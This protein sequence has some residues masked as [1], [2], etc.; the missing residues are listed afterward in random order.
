[1]AQ[2]LDL[3][4]FQRIVGGARRACAHHAFDLNTKLVAHVLG[5][6]KRRRAVRVADDLHIAFAVAQ[7]DENNAAMVAPAVHPAAQTD[8]LTQ[9]GFGD[10]TTIVRTHLGNDGHRKY[11]G[12]SA[13]AQLK[14]RSQRGCTGFF[15]GRNHAH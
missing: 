13:A 4:A 1:M 5:D 10:E 15:G 9:Q 3:A 14:G 11:L 2:H 8:R 6:L 12:F 7:I